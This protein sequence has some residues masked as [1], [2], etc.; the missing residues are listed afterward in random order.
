M[1]DAVDEVDA[2]ATI[3]QDADGMLGSRLRLDDDLTATATGT[4][5]LCH[6]FT[7]GAT[8]GNGEGIDSHIGI[9][10]TSSKEGCTL[11]TETRGIGGILLIAANDLSSVIQTDGGTHMEV[12]VGGIA[13]LRGFDGQRYEMLVGRREF[14]H[15]TDVNDGF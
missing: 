4:A 3:E 15:L 7:I 8:G 2:T 13:A 9:L 14:F 11:C 10:G 12:G 1:T 6:E 5:G